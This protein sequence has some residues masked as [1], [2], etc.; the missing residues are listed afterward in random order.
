MFSTFVL[1]DWN[2]IY[3]EHGNTACKNKFAAGSQVCTPDKSWRE[4]GYD[5]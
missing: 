3:I 5:F 4:A 2:V 1:Y